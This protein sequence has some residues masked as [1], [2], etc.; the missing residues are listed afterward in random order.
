MLHL[1]RS[2]SLHTLADFLVEQRAATPFSLTP[3]PLIVPSKA[4]Q[5]WLEIQIA[6]RTGIA[7]HLA[8][9]YPAQFLWRCVAQTLPQVSEQSP[10]DLTPLSGRIYRLLEPLTRNN[11]HPTLARY[12]QHNTPV[13]RLQLA[14]RIAQVFDHYLVYRPHWLRHWAN[15]KKVFFAHEGELQNAD[16]SQAD[17]QTQRWQQAL[18]QALLKDLQL[19]HNDHPIELFLQALQK[20]SLSGTD[21]GLP[22]SLHLFAIPT[23]A[24][25]YE[26]VFQELARYVPVFVYALQPTPE[27]LKEAPQRLMRALGK[28][29]SVA[30][31][32]G[33]A[34]EESAAVTQEKFIA[35]SAPHLLGQLQRAVFELNPAPLFQRAQDDHSIQIKIAHSL[36]RE[37]EV[38]H[39]GL[40]QCFNTTPGLQLQDVVV[41]LPNL[42]S[43]APAIH[44]V[45]G[46]AGQFPYT[47]TGLPHD[48]AGAL[49]RAYLQLFDLAASRWLADELWALWCVPACRRRFGWDDA[50]LE[51]LRGL[52]DAA[53]VRWGR[54]AA[55]RAVLGVSAEPA[56]TWRWALDRLLLSVAD[57]HSAEQ[58]FAGVAGV[59][60]LSLE[61]SQT[62]P[63]L[64]VALEKLGQLRED[65][66]QA[67]SPKAWVR[68]LEQSFDDFFAPAPAEKAAAYAVHQALHQLQENAA[69]AAWHD[70]VDFSVMQ[71]LL[72]Q[73]LQGDSSGAIPTGTLTFAQLG[74]LHSLPYR[75][76]C[77]LG[78]DAEA[79]PRRVIPTEFDL[80][81]RQAQGGDPDPRAD[82]QSAF[83]HALLSAQDLLWLS[84]TGLNNRDNQACPPSAV[85]AELLDFLQYSVTP[86]VQSLHAPS[87]FAPTAHPHQ[88]DPT[89][90]KLAPPD[91]SQKLISP[92]HLIEFLAHPL[93]YFLQQRL[94]LSPRLKAQS[95]DNEEPFDLSGLDAWQARD[96]LL[97]RLRRGEAPAAIRQL[98]RAQGALPAGRTGDFTFTRLQQEVAPLLAGLSEFPAPRF[99]LP[100]HI[101]HGEFQIQGVLHDVHAHGAVLVSASKTNPKLRAAAWVTAL[102]L[103]VQRP[104]T[105]TVTLIADDGHRTFTVSTQDAPAQ[106][107][108]LLNHYWQGLQQPWLCPP[109]S[110][111]AW[112]KKQQ[113]SEAEKEWRSGYQHTGE[114]QDPWWQ[115]WLSHTQINTALNTSSDDLPEAFEASA[116]QL[117]RALWLASTTK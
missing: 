61:Q 22:P 73:L 68:F 56:H 81:A 32:G 108:Q 10:F 13:V 65:L 59:G 43:A 72:K 23:L 83:L 76:V 8:F 27:Y 45:F 20:N 29:D 82:D 94:Q 69:R 78:L 38:L 47:L 79:F 52:L 19:P 34:L 35:P 96:D 28:R 98:W 44:A 95:L 100:V 50:D 12:W 54:D 99:T 104:D 51:Q 92:E 75:V 46:S 57:P 110:A 84:Y 112:L 102:L 70:P 103:A 49:G 37:L 2:N 66:Q 117:Y 7:C 64:V 101:T 116:E 77:V 31:Q 42:A 87:R 85:L 1:F 33:I 106:L 15:N 60:E 111:W 16:T 24:P 109:K 36:V 71:H 74:A 113:R 14:E 11:E 115:L 90:E 5:R 53:A 97:Q 80:M 58:P 107:T 30:Q 26:R 114:N 17:A 25:L 63:G 4:V 88:T 91:A 55:H 89:G 93:R 9:A 41:V 6:Q 48:S 39:D 86:E 3:T 62:L 18:W 21:P 67:R 40:V 105:Q